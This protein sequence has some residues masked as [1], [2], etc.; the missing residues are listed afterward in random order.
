MQMCGQRWLCGKLCSLFLAVELSLRY[1]HEEIP[2]Q[3]SV[4]VYSCPMNSVLVF[5]YR[6]E[7]ISCVS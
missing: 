7:R 4:H 5:L 3:E 6:T 1:T 2:H